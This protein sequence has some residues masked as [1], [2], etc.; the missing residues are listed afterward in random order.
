MV[1]V[2]GK[3]IHFGQPGAQTYVD[4]ASEDKKKAYL[5]RHKVN[6]DWTK[7]DTAGY[8]ARWILWGDTRSIKK[9]YSLKGV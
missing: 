6:E 3:V 9:N 8:W 7:K 5:A 2:N 1:E 4:G